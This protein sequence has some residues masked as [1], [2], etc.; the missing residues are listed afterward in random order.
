MQINKIS[1]GNEKK[2]KQYEC[3]Y[4]LIKIK[5][6]E[7]EREREDLTVNQIPVIFIIKNNGSTK[8]GTLGIL[9]LIFES[10][11][12]SHYQSKPPTFIEL[13]TIA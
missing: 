3:K 4:D 5:E 11:F 9:N 1:A 10:T 2:I 7:R 13:E 8:T 6:R 12:T